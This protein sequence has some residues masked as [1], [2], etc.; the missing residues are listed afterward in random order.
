VQQLKYLN[1][2]L[3]FA[4]ASALS[5]MLAAC[6]TPQPAPTTG[7]GDDGA[8]AAAQPVKPK[9]DRVVLAIPPFGIEGNDI[10]HWGAPSAVQLRPM[11]DKLIG[12]DPKTNKLVPELA[13]AWKVEPDGKSYRFTLQKGVQ[14][15]DGAGE[16]TSKDV[17]M[18]YTNMTYDGV[19]ASNGPIFRALIEDV[20][21]V[22]DYETVTKLK[23]PDAEFLLNISQMVGG[24]E[25]VSKVDFDKR[26]GV[27][28]TMSTRPLAGTG[29]Y[30]F[31]E[32]QQGAFVRFE[33]AP[34]K[35]YR[36]TPDFP[37]LE[38]RMVG[39]ASTRMA[40]L[41]TGEIHMAPLPDDLIEQVE[42]QQMKLVKGTTPALRTFLGF[43]GQYLLDKDDPSKGYKFPDSPIMN[44]KVRQAL[45]KAVNRDELNKAFFRGKAQTMVLDAYHP[46]RQ[47][48]NPEW[49]RRFPEMYG[50]DAD[51]AKALLAEAGYNDRNP[52]VIE[53]LMTRLTDV[54]A[55]M[56]IQ[57]AVANYWRRIGV[58]AKLVTMDPAEMS[59]KQRQME[60][61]RHATIIS[62]AA[63]NFTG[64]RVYKTAL[65]GIRGIAVEIP[66]VNDLYRKVAVMLDEE[67]QTPVW[68]DLG[69]KS[70]DAFQNIPLFW[71][72]TQLA[73]NPKFVADYLF[74]GSISGSWTHLENI[75]AAP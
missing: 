52:L 67:A 2:P 51:K 11:Y 32:R 46:T 36:V 70:F 66:D 59:L 47:G 7:A 64:V 21:L 74:P 8:P 75:K 44:A 62:T 18:T 15:H 33:R 61:N 10:G 20:E 63:H 25:I 13:S 14:M 54:P 3:V 53:M 5:L 55:S 41:L 57:E 35:H 30:M 31:K 27:Y 48:W 29:A 37:Q 22:N 65:H 34:G 4:G 1:R 58:D 28:P 43:R 72:D 23:S 73:V 26:G 68:R 16:F 42:R 56:D 6:S 17:K 39:E 71:L 12:V 45:S 9:V 40:G 69:N 19:T 24:F 50:F 60:F 49:E 38:L